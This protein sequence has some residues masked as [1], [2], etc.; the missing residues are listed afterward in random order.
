MKN[1]KIKN[2]EDVSVFNNCVS[3]MRDT[4]RGVPLEN[5]PRLIGIKSLI[6]QRYT[7]YEGL[8]SNNQL[9]N[10][11]NTTTDADQKASLIYLYESD[12]KHVKKLKET[13]R[14]S[15]DEHLQYI[16]PNCG[17]LPSDTMDHY[18]PKD[19]HP[20]FVLLSKNLIWSCG[21][22]NRKKSEFWRESGRTGIINFYIDKIPSFRFLNCKITTNNNK[23]KATW[24]L[25]VD[26]LTLYPTIIKH[27]ERLG[28]TKLYNDHGPAKLNEL[29]SE[30]S[31]Y[32]GIVPHNQV[33]LILIRQYCSRVRDFGINEWKASLLRAF[34]IGK[35]YEN[36]L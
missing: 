32:K 30:I 21:T 14:N 25:L 11:S 7:E 17:I 31:S 22:C 36:Y 35:L 34:I 4:Y 19:E 16:C 8:F 12:N 5:K 2:I 1:R 33:R 24:E 13:I 6:S 26:K 18:V 10:I 29:I 23:P 9:V 3:A 27:Y 28:I 20:D 15:Q